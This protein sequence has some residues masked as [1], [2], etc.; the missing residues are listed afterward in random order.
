LTPLPGALGGTELFAWRLEREIYAATWDSGEGA[1]RV[2]GRWSTPGRRVLYTSIDPATAILEV[3]VHKGFA[4]LDSV[5]HAL[6][7]L[8]VDP[9]AV[10]I[11]DRALV[12]NPHWL[13][14]GVVSSNQ[15]KF[16]NALLDQYPILALPSVVSAYS[17]NL[18]IDLASAAGKFALL[19]QERFA[20]DPRLA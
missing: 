4:V 7:C 3:A 19:K 18:V 13:H 20:L 16:G 10:Q 12:P 17:W 14:P 2:G 11:L 6:L 1:Y 15:Q 5:A 8:R 9:S